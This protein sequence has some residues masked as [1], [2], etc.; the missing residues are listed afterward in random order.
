[1]RHLK[2]RIKLSRQTSHRNAVLVNL[3][4]AVI[5]H[6]RIKT[7]KTKAKMVQPYIEKLVTRAKDNTL[8]NKRI[9]ASRMK[10]WD[11]IPKLFDKI[12]PAFKERPGGYTRIIKLGFRNSDGAEM[13][14]FEFIEEFD[15]GIEKEKLKEVKKEKTVK[16]ED[17][18][19]D[20]KKE[21][22]TDIKPDKE[23][24]KKR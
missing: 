19:E 20:K 5:R 16:S 9:V 4:K 13:V 21:K 23:K 24:K 12:G 18:K 14:I 8:H 2:K 17:R 1:M 22:T 7:T 11:I 6:G 10:S 15:K 3:C